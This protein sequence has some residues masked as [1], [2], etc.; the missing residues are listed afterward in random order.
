[1]GLEVVNFFFSIILGSSFEI[2]IDLRCCK[3][4]QRIPTQPSSSRIPH[5]S[6]YVRL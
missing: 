5:E 4:D 1:M 6:M 3:L 2:T